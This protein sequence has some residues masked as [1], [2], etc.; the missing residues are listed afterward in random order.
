[1]KVFWMIPVVLGFAVPTAASAEETATT[2]CAET[3]AAAVAAFESG[4]KLAGA[5]GYRVTSLR[6]DAVL[7]MNWAAVERCGH[8]GWP[9]VAVPSK[10]APVPTAAE[11]A[12]VRAGGRVLG[13]G[14]VER[15]APLVRVGETV[16]LWQQDRNVRLQLA[17]VSEE[18]GAVGDRV[19]LRMGDRLAGGDGPRTVYGMVRGVR[20]VEME[21]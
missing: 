21:R 5:E 16:R 4:A 11:V 7:G 15:R 17:A 13:G 2:P 14:I 6:R 9:A 10:M 18:N 8:P 12:A 3:P 19:R 1:M 20:D